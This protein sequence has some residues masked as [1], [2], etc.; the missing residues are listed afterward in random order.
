[1]AVVKADA[2][3]H[4][5]TQIAAKISSTVHGFAVNSLQEGAELR[6]SGINSPILVFE[7][8]AAKT[9]ALYN[10]YDL[11][12]TIS[13]LQHFRILPAKTDYHL[14]FDTGMGRL[15][16]RPESASEVAKLVT[17]HDDLH[18]KGIYS[19][20]ATADEP[21]S[22]KAEEQ[23]QV[24]ANQICSNFPPNLLRH[25]CNTAGIVNRPVSHFDMVRA[26][27]G[28][29]G[30]APGGVSIPGLTPALTWKTSLVQVKRIK[31]GE[32][33]SY[34]AAWKAPEDGFCGIIPV[35]YADGI[36]RSLSGKFQVSINGET[37][38]VVGRVTMN[39]CIVFLG[40]NRLPTGSDVFL[41]NERHTALF[42]ANT[43]GTI[44]YEILTT[45]SPFVPRHYLEDAN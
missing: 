6:K 15:G 4:G 44:S 28:L 41:L 35:G 14:N 27:I 22:P 38:P 37:Y 9:T 33:V 29:Y 31:Q 21:G 2:Y 12:A 30:Y 43:I 26:G 8:P 10:E 3:G 45:I 39:Y 36:P 16:F 24:F 5:A 34:G 23:H 40:R 17:K 32:T 20:F 19:H 42:W 25:I 1:M 13:D 18:C 11:T 7:P